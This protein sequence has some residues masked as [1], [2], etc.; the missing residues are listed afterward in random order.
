ML[1]QMRAKALYVWIIIA[2]VFVGSFV[3][4]ETSGLMGRNPVSTTTAVGT[5]NGR[6]I[7]YTVWLE[8]TQQFAQQQEQQQG[9]ALTMDERKVAENQAFNELV[10]QL[11]LDEEYKRRGIR[12]SD[13][14]IVDMAK[15]NP[16]PQ[17]QQLPDLQTDGRFDP[18]KYQRFLASPAARQQGILVNLENYFRTEIPKQKLF[19]Q[20]AGDVYVSDARLWSIY[21]DT[22]DSATV[23]YVAFKPVPTKE[24]RDAVTDAEMTAYY[25]TH[26]TDFDRPGSAVLS[27]V[28]IS[29]RA[30]AAD[31]AETLKKI[32]A[33]R[34][35]I[36]KGAKFEDVAKR[37]SDDSVSGSKGGDL[38][39]S[40]KGGFVK[41][42]DAAVFS[43]PIGTL[44]Q[45]VKTDYGYH[46]VR[47]DKRTGDTAFVHHILKLVK[48]GDSAAVKTDRQ[49]DSLA[50]FA[51]SALT[52]TAFDTAAKKMGL[53]VSRINV[54]EGQPAQYLGR[55]VPS[56]SAWAFSG[57]RPGESSDLFD[58]DAGY[59]LVRL[60]SIRQK[61]V[62]TVADVKNEL[63]DAV[64]RQKALDTV[65]AKAKEMA[66]AAA[67]STLEAAAKTT[68]RPVEKEGPF[69]RSSQVAAFGFVSEVS[70]AAMALPVGS[71]SEPVRTEDGVFVIRVDKRVVADTVK[72]GAQK[73]TQRLQVTNSLRDQRVRMYVENLRRAAKIKD[74]RQEINALQRR[75]T[76]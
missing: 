65:M 11:L 49:A 54:T 24:E 47:V 3:F 40:V 53:L 42:F 57:A 9:R 67:G 62:A 25:N 68:G 14:E 13:A 30:T 22:H 52:P 32:Q 56:A 76:T 74:R 58:D 16:P 4:Y 71:V 50:K 28:S 18:A 38:G 8:V 29:R 75:A 34:D 10:S 64:A 33:I 17:F 72:F 43:L 20:I 45:P 35:E 6:D 37:E 19:Q 61:G 27:I 51:A 23:S 2:I 1:H 36:A 46:V 15:Y 48:Q 69:A 31:S 21:R 55:Q 60:D 5:V 59:Y 44:S 73:A 63:R 26:K 12:V 66:K 7:L 41:Q 39:R 70:G